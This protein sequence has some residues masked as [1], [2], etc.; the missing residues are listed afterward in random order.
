MISDRHPAVAV[1][2]AAE[3][4]IKRLSLALKAVQTSGSAEELERLRKSIGE[5]LGVLETEV[6]WPLYRRHPDLEPDNLK[7]WESDHEG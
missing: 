4:F 1:A 3:E 7:N 5:V 6:L 2:A